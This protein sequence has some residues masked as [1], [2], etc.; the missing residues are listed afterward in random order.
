MYKIIF[1][2][3]DG[4]L[5]NDEKEISN[6]TKK[7]IHRMVEKGIQIVICSGRH[8]QFVEEVSKEAL[9]SGYIISCNGGEIYDYEKKEVIYENNLN[10]E[11][12][13]ALYQMAEKYDAQVIINSR[14]KRVVKKQSEDKTDILLKEPIEEF[15]KHNTVT[16]CIFTDRNLNK[17]QKIKEEIENRK[18]LEIPN[19][20]KSL[21]NPVIQPESSLFLDVTRKGTSKGVAIK[22]LC[23]Y[24]HINLK[25]SVAIGD[26]YNDLTMFEAVGHAVAMGNA[27]EDIKKTVDEVTDTNNEDGVAKFLE[28]IDKEGI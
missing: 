12:I 7:A 5:R 10:N 2:D 8:R 23:A 24:L 13:L 20:S 15:V 21:I 25:D 18:E 16:Q 26:S 6:R 28:N 17:I 9:A 14:E 22:K 19:L 27:L 11:E 1:I 3:I 4:T